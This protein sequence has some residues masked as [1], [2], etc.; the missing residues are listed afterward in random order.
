MDSTN[1]NQNDTNNDKDDEKK[2]IKTN[3][4]E[5]ICR[6][7]TRAFFAEHS[8]VAMHIRS[9]NYFVTDLIP[10]IVRERNVLVVR[11]RSTSFVHVVR[12]GQ[13][14]YCKP[15][16]M[17][18]GKYLR[19]I[20]PSEARMKGLNYSFSVFVDMVHE[21]YENPTKNP[22]I[23]GTLME[24]KQYREM[25]ICDIPA[26]VGSIMCYTVDNFDP[27]EHDECIYDT[28]GYYIVNGNPKVMMPQINMRVNCP[29]ISECKTYREEKKN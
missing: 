2:F 27:I 25:S 26:M 1:K 28:G 24:C 11:S 29:Y 9:F 20:M 17:T 18:P 8:L 7:V 14:T 22:D 12:F 23:Y 13:V 3:M 15:T 6:D 16:V 19:R 10:Q 5:Q 21:V 4:S